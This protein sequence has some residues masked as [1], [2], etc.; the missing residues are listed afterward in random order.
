MHLDLVIGLFLIFFVVIVPILGLTA[1]FALKP[2]VDSLLALRES[3]REEPKRPG[4]DDRILELEEEVA[5]L[6]RAVR[7]LE[8]ARSWDDSL[9]APPGQ[10]NRPLPESGG[11]GGSEGGRQG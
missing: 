9:L 4:R 3:L 11:R 10:R 6:R 8:E 7:A 5:L 1:R 2:V